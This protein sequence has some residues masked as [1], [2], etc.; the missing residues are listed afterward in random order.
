MPNK[1]NYS[2]ALERAADRIERHAEKRA[3]VAVFLSPDFV[4]RSSAKADLTLIPNH[5][6]VGVYA[7]WR[8]AYQRPYLRDDL[9]LT[10]K[11]LD[12]SA[13]L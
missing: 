10:L 5:R 3:T 13:D 9:I 4:L 2:E 6:L 1:P 8:V 12:V 11:A 7:G